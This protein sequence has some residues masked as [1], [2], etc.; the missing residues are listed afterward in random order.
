MKASLLFLAALGTSLSAMAADGKPGH[1]RRPDPERMAARMI[2]KND[3]N[4]DKVL[5][6]SELTAA[7]TKIQERMDKRRAERDRE[8]AEDEADGLPVPP[9]RPD[10]PDRPAPAAQAHAWM[11]AYDADHSSTLDAKELAQ[12]IQETF[13]NRKRAW[14]DGKDCPQ[15]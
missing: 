3:T 7:L 15:G 8:R 11:L 6:E 9:P 1:H 4:G 5:G 10:R 2:E 14:R 12:A 13:E